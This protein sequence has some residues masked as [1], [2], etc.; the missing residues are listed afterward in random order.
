MF[1]AFGTRGVECLVGKPP[2]PPSAVN[3]VRA[4]VHRYCHTLQSVGIRSPFNVEH[5]A[6]IR[7]DLS[8]VN[9]PRVAG[10]QLVNLVRSRT[11]IERVL[12]PN[13]NFPVPLAVQRNAD[14]FPEDCAFQLNED[15]VAGL[16]FQFETTK[17]GRGGRCY[18]PYAFTEQG[19]AMLS[20]VL[21]SPSAVQVNIAI[22]RA[23]VRLREML[24]SNADLARKLIALE[25]KY[26]ASL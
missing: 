22:M 24:M 8:R 7:F 25:N 14:R 23:F 13:S 18:R 17:R 21:R 12:L 4:I 26:D 3:A 19:V 2:A 15:E 16:R 11:R 10:R 5:S 6:Q 1:S 9:R 20:S